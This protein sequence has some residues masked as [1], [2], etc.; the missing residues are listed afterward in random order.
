MSRE[1]TTFEMYRDSAFLHLLLET[2]IE[3][4]WS[5]GSFVCGKLKVVPV[6]FFM[7]D[8]TSSSLLCA[9]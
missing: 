7:A 9:R 6:F 8:V 3:D 1:C 4:F 2:P 5:E